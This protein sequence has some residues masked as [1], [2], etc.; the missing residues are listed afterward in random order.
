M[1]KAT[2]TAR[3][4]WL[5]IV[6]VCGMTASAGWPKTLWRPPAIGSSAEAARPSRMSRRP[7]LATR[8]ACADRVR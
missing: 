4:R 8:P 2:P 3:G 6:E 1:A 7:S 5:A